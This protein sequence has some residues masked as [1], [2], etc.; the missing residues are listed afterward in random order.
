[1]AKLNWN[2]HHLTHG[3]Q[4]SITAHDDIEGSQQNEFK[5]ARDARDKDGIAVEVPA[6]AVI[7]FHSHLLHKS[8]NNHSQ[9]FRRSYVAHY[10]SAQA[11][12]VNPEKSGKGQ[13]IMWIRGQTFPGKVQEVEHDVLPV[14]D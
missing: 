6:G 11:E 2:S 14:D 8:T 13:P 5:L 3:W 1:M 12:W 4:K 9:R 10:L 7:W